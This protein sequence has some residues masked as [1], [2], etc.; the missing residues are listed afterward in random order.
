[1]AVL[2]IPCALGFNL[3]SGIEPMGKGSM[4]LDLE[5]FIV[6]NNLLP[7]GSIVYLLFCVSKKGWGWDNFIKEVDT[8]N[9]IRFP[10]AL[11]SYFIWGLPLLVLLVFIF[12]YIN[13]FL[14]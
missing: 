3:L 10:S 7:L 8:G 13:K 6:S 5:D 9:G 2:S 4:I 1:V 12:G 14:G 11:R